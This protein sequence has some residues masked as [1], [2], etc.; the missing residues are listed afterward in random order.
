MCACVRVCVCVSMASWWQVTL[1]AGGSRTEQRYS[2]G[3]V[4]SFGGCEAM[5]AAG[6]GEG[7]AAV[8]PEARR[9]QR[10]HVEVKGAYANSE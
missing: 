4:A 6:G 5:D 9:V 3:C 10:R 8:P 2:L 1:P 7:R